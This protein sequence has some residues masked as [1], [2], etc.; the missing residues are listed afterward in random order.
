[1]RPTSVCQSKCG[2]GTV[3]PNPA[4]SANSSAKRAPWPRL[5]VVGFG[6]YEFLY[7]AEY[8]IWYLAEYW[9][10]ALLSPDLPFDDRRGFWSFAKFVRTMMRPTYT[11]PSRSAVSSMR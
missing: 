4:A 2:V 11:T 6:A 10:W 8:W 7:L 1:L 3:Q 5:V 9:I